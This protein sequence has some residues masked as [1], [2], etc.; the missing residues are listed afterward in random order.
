MFTPTP[1]EHSSMQLLL[2]RV[3]RLSTHAGIDLVNQRRD[4]EQVIAR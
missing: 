1:P 2:V 4:P 3:T